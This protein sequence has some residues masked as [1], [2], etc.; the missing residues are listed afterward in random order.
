MTLL[1]DIAK[2]ALLEQ[3]ARDQLSEDQGDSPANTETLALRSQLASVRA[4]L[5]GLLRQWDDPTEVPSATPP[6][7]FDVTDDGGSK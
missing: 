1:Q 3:R 7:A 2:A 5:R 6:P 4:K